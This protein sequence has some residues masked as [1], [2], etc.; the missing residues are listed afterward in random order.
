MEP[1]RGCA[2]RGSCSWPAPAAG[3]WVG[4]GTRKA[5]AISSVVS[6]PRVR[7]VSATCA[8]GE[9]AGW[10]QVKIR[11]SRSSGTGRPPLGRSSD[12]RDFL[13][14][15]ASASRRS[16]SMALCRAV[17][18]SHAPGSPARPP[19]PLLERHRERLLQRLLG[20]VEVAEEADQCGQ[21]RPCSRRERCPRC[22]WPPGIHGTLTGRRHATRLR[23]RPL[24]TAECRHDHLLLSAARA[25]AGGRRA[26]HCVASATAFICAQAIVE[27]SRRS[28]CPCP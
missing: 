14:F 16:R 28:S 15:W 3:P 13:R 7:R 12:A 4:D 17:G 21:A 19:R 18:T 27:L 2:R 22:A 11:R 24:V 25:R 6:P 9:S 5:R 8:S 10:Q 20:H 23:R 1:G 26:I